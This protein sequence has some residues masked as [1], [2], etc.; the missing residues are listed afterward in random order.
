M[1]GGKKSLKLD[2]LSGAKKILLHK[3]HLSIKGLIETPREVKGP[4]LCKDL[5]PKRNYAAYVLFTGPPYLRD[6]SVSQWGYDS[7]CGCWEKNFGELNTGVG[8]Y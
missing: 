2:L 5:S 6:L 3:E 4:I 1:L 8:E 7:S